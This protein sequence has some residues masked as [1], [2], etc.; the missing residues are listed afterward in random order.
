MRRGKNNTG[1][2]QEEGAEGTAQNPYEHS[3]KAIATV[4]T[5]EDFWRVYNYLARPNDLPSTTDY[6][7]FREGKFRKL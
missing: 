5:V 6:H 7:F 1:T 2:K 3:I 4:N